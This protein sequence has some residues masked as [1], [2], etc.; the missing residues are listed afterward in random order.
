MKIRERHSLL[1][2]ESCCGHL[3][4]STY[5]FASEKLAYDNENITNPNDIIEKKNEKRYISLTRKM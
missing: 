1:G 3:P 2:G 4:S 5:I